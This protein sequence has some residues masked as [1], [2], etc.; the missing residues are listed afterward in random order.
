MRLVFL[1][2][3]I[4]ALC[5]SP[6]GIGQYVGVKRTWPILELKGLVAKPWE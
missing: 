4:V 1:V 6:F 2:P 3:L 5:I